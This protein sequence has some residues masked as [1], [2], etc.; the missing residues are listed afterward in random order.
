[1]L[2]ENIKET[3]TLSSQRST[4]FINNQFKMIIRGRGSYACRKKQIRKNQCPLC[5]NGTQLSW[6][7]Q[8]ST[9]HEKDWWQHRKT[10]ALLLWC[11]YLIKSSVNP[12]G[13]RNDPISL[14]WLLSTHSMLEKNSPLLGREGAGKFI[15]S[16]YASDWSRN[17]K[18]AK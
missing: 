8:K 10:L 18:D 5:F 14:T 15:F 2:Q 12:L 16:E 1:M 11:L 3:W 4:F 7:H 17:S 13:E 6:P 9:V